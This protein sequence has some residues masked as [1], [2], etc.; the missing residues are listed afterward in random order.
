MV[1][2][3]QQMADTMITQVATNK[4]WYF[5]LGISEYFKSLDYKHKSLG[6]TRVFQK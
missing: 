1:V 2:A 6:N 3:W 5:C 4:F